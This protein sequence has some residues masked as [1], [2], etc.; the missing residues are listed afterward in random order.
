MCRLLGHAPNA[1]PFGKGIRFLSKSDVE[2][3]MVLRYLQAAA[4][5]D[6][7]VAWFCYALE[8]EKLIKVGIRGLPVDTA[9]DMILAALQELE[10]P[11]EY[12]RHIPPSKKVN[13][14]ACFMPSLDI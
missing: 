4:W 7:Q 14:A 1:R 10:F 3:R 9:P 2:F 8:T 6:H 5:R 11:A 12:V 13:P